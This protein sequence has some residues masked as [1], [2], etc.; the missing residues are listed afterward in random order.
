MQAD[1]PK[2]LNFDE[3]LQRATNPNI[4]DKV[5]TE[6]TKQNFNAKLL[7]LDPQITTATDAQS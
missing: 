1:K 4:N 6:L 2:R 7:E 5:F 3:L